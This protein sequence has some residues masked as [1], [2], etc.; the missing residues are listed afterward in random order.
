VA[1][2]SGYELAP[3]RVW[4]E[5]AGP[6]APS[7]PQSRERARRVLNIAVAA[8]GLVLAAPLMLV[9][10]VLIKLTS[11]GPIFYSQIRIGLD[12]RD[13]GKAAGNGRRRTNAGGRPFRI[14]KF[15]TMAP[16]SGSTQVWARPDDPRVT[17]IGRILRKYRLD[18]LPQLVN[19]LRGDMNVV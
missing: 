6:H 18:E 16:S 19:V 17:A 3:S 11:R 2:A 5:E 7:V 9:I 15:R 1:N 13:Q 4:V 10:A 8:L 14:Y 12:V